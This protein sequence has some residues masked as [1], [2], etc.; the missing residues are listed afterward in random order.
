MLALLFADETALIDS[1]D[2]IQ[3]LKK[4][5]GYFRLNTL[6]LHPEKTKYLIFPTTTLVQTS[7]FDVFM[8]AV[9]KIVVATQ[10]LGAAPPSH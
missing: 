10:F 4:I 2:D 3:R 5:C 8:A 6:L 1:D 7:S 9:A